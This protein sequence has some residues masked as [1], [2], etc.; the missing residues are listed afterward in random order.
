LIGLPDFNLSEDC[1]LADFFLTLLTVFG[2]TETDFL[3]FGVS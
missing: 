3:G 2:F 1:G